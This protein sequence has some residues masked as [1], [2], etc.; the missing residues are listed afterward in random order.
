[1]SNTNPKQVVDKFQFFIDTHFETEDQYIGHKYIYGL[2][3][4]KKLKEYLTNNLKKAGINL[5]DFNRNK[6]DELVGNPPTEIYEYQPFFLLRRKDGELVLLDGFRRLLWYNSPDHQIHVRIYNEID[7]TNHDI[8][9]LLIYLN[10]FKFY[11]G[12]GRYYDRGFALGM[13]TIFGLNIPKYYTTFDAYLTKSDVEKK[14]WGEST[15]DTSDNLNVKERMLN[16]MFISD[17]KFIEGLV[18]TG[19]MVTP[20]MGAL[21]YKM[22]IEHPDTEFSSE[23]FL[24][25]VKENTILLNLQEKFN[26]VGDGYGAE[27]QKIVNQIVPLYKN[28]FNE[29][30]GGEIIVTY[31]EKKD[32]VK[33]L[34]E[35]HKKDKTYTKLTGSKSG[36][37]MEIIMKGRLINKKPLNFKC[38]VHPTEPNPY[39]YINYL[40][41]NKIAPIEHGLLPYEVKFITTQKKSLGIVD[42]VFGFNDKD[43]HE[44]RFT[45]NYG[46]YYVWAKKYTGINGGGV[47]SIRYDVDLF[48]NITKS[49]IVE[50]EKNRKYNG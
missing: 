8:M 41:E 44:F 14:Y 20:I 1:M 32:E 3:N 17:M 48:V 11:A 27:A 37:L 26:K 38:I 29:M 12:G 15:D 23:F 16:P 49:E 31:A 25:K 18:D 45:H 24:N 19:V 5:E 35:Q 30:L 21:V 36:Y 10:H 2:G 33:K 47:P 28:I 39:K 4:A 50:T 7:L 13:K 22:R 34:I 6:S 46:G 42:L 9:K 40:D 43:G